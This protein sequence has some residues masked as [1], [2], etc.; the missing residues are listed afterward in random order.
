[1]AIDER[2]TSR[3]LI[4]D[5]VEANRFILRDIIEGMGCQP[6]LAENGEQALKI[7]DRIDVNLII[8][9]IAMPVMD[10]YEFCSILKTNVKTKSIPV[11]FISAFDDPSDVVKGFNIGGEDYITKPFI[12][13]VVKVRVRLHLKL[14]DANK[15]LQETNRKLQLSVTNQLIQMENEKK[16]VLYALGRVARENAS[17]AETNMER[18]S[19]N[20]RIL[21]EAMQLSQTFD[22]VISDDFI[23]TIEIA[24][25]LCD[26]GNMAI[27]TEILQKKDSLSDEEAEVM[28]T[29]TT[30]G[31]KILSDIEKSSGRN[32]FLRMSVDIA[33]FHHENWDGNGYPTKRAGNEIPIAAQIVAIVS[34]FCALTET[35]TYRG[36]YTKEEAVNIIG[37][38]CGTKYS[39][40]IFNIVKMIYKQFI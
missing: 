34:A 9:D 22:S 38:E 17:Y 4:V 21:S 33:K 40:D 10:G 12:P 11:I 27:S 39:P 24:A 13:E 28:R 14:F 3:I 16:N 15:N 2:T 5:D 18:L 37:E 25:P 29:H 1:M 31:A 8:S 23:N 30:I 32:D 20:C 6:I 35:R 19:A 36:S 7:V 26:L